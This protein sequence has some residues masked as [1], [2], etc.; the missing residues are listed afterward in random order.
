MVRNTIA[1]V[2]LVLV[3]CALAITPSHSWTVRPD[4]NYNFTWGLSPDKSHIY[5]TVSVI[6]PVGVWVGVGWHP[7]GS[8]DNA[9]T[10]ADFVIATF[11]EQGLLETVTD[12]FASK[13]NSGFAPPLLDTAKPFPDGRDDIKSY[14]GMQIRPP[15]T[16][17]GNVTTEFSFVRALNTGDTHADHPITAG[18]MK[19]LWAHGSSNKFSFHGQ[20]NAGQYNLNFFTGAYST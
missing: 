3:A 10:K 17:S 13:E 4:P 18:T 20:G 5:A 1:L 12:R 19:V 6:A 11:D 7:V 15:A 2:A 14:S 9:M 16:S 8:P